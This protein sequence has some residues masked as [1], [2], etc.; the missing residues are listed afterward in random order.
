[1]LTQAP[2]PPPPLATNTKSTRLTTT[3]K[4]QTQTPAQ[5]RANDA[6]A[7][8]QETK[9]GKP[10]PVL[11]KTV[12]QKSPISKTWLCMLGKEKEKMCKMERKAGTN[13][14]TFLSCQTVA[15]VFVVCGGLIFELLRLVFGYF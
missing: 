1:L 13:I 6:F 8:K 7:K 9:R 4:T 2:P 15:L 3:T 11:K 5:R 12:I 14:F 10:E